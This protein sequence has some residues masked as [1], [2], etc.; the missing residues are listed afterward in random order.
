MHTSADFSVG[1]YASSWIIPA[2]P[3][4]SAHFGPRRLCPKRHKT[5]PCPTPVAVF[6]PSSRKVEQPLVR[7]ESKQPETRVHDLTDPSMVFENFD[8]SPNPQSVSV[9]GTLPYYLHNHN[10]YRLGPARFEEPHKDGI[11]WKATH[12]FDGISMLSSFHFDVTKSSVVFRSRI[13]SNR[14]LRAIRET[15]STEYR[16]FVISPCE[17]PLWQQLSSWRMPTFDSEVRVPYLNYGVTL[18]QIPGR[19]LCARTDGSIS[20]IIDPKTL[21]PLGQFRFSELHPKLTGSGSMAHGMFDDTTGEY[22]NIVWDYYPGKVNYHI[23]C[24]NSKGRTR[25]VSTIRSEARYMHAAAITDKYVI[26]GFTPVRIDFLKLLFSMS[27][28]DAISVPKEEGVKFV[29]VS[30]KTGEVVNTFEQ[31]YFSFMHVANAF[32]RDGDVVLDVV[33]AIGLEDLTSFDMNTV[34]TKGQLPPA[35][36]LYRVVL[37]NVARSATRS[38]SKSPSRDMKVK[39]VAKGAGDMPSISP[40]YKQKSYKYVYTSC[41]HEN[42]FDGSVQK[43]DLMTGEAIRFVKAGHIL[44][45]PMFVPSPSGTAEDDGCVLVLAL[46]TITRQSTLIILDAKEFVEISRAEFPVAMPSGLHGYFGRAS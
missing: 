10:Y 9:T 32:D 1:I 13:N 43:I 45:E 3:L 35:S 26:I 7:E 5:V 29:L 22:F 46:N 16:N 34:K 37:R 38:P 41:H 24:I 40:L 25:L 42:V 19:G 31:E 36:S 21:N 4:K 20:Q 6:Q 33:S 30:R 11:M 28:S 27:L 15:P 12:L 17:K 18:E 23:F 39:T 8:E 2:L 14:L 44:G